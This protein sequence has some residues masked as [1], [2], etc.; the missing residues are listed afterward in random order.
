MGLGAERKMN[1]LKA[2]TQEKKENFNY[3]HAD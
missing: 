2:M 1:P 3:A